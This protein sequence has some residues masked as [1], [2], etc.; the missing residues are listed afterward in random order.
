MVKTRRPDDVVV[1]GAIHGDPG[2]VARAQ[3]DVRQVFSQPPYG[4]WALVSGSGADP[5]VESLDGVQ[6]NRLGDRWRISAADHDTLLTAI[7]KGTRPPERLR[8]EIDPLEL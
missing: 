2:R 4:A 1:Q 7:G 5:F 6:C 3:R 8:I